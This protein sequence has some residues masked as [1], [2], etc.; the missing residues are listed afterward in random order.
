MTCALKLRCRN[1]NIPDSFNLHAHGPGLGAKRGND[2]AL[3]NNELSELDGVVASSAWLGGRGHQV[4]EL[5][6]ST[7]K[8][9]TTVNKSVHCL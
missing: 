1:V 4:G 9:A 6:A 8:A 2:F 3:F 7:L 5:T